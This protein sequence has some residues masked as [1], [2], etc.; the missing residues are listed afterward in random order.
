[1]ILH[2]NVKF[3]RVFGQ[4]LDWL[5]AADALQAHHKTPLV[6]A[7]V[8]TFD[9]PVI[10]ALRMWIQQHPDRESLEAASLALSEADRSIVWTQQALV[11]DLLRAAEAFGTECHQTVGANLA[12]AARSNSTLG[13]TLGGQAAGEGE[14]MAN[15]RRIM[16]EL[17]IGSSAR[18]FYREL[19]DS[20]EH[21]L[22]WL[23]SSPFA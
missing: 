18:R 3:D 4:L 16:A 14:L 15:A 5:R 8:G 9:D 11:V 2:D 20:A 10:A 19:A 12:K 6:K 22:Q 23:S 1:M 13:T 21:M 17:P 7:I